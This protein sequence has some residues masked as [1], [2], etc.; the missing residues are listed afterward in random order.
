MHL[1]Q[2][3]NCFGCSRSLSVGDDVEGAEVGDEWSYLCR[4]CC[5][6]VS[7]GGR[8]AHQTIEAILILNNDPDVGGPRDPLDHEDYRDLELLGILPKE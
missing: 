7:R 4:D 6:K 1:Q 5:K 2:P 8:T 3:A